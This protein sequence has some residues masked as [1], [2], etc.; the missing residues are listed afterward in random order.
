MRPLVLWLFLDW[1]LSR[2][3]PPFT[4]WPFFLELYI[5]FLP[6]DWRDIRQQQLL[7]LPQWVLYLLSFTSFRNL[8]Y[9]IVQFWTT[10][11]FI[12]SMAAELGLHLCP[13]QSVYNKLGPGTAPQWPVPNSTP[14]TFPTACYVSYFLIA[15]VVWIFQVRGFFV[16]F[17]V[18][19]SV[20][21]E[22]GLTVFNWRYYQS[23]IALYF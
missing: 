20:R 4:A 7:W 12:N 3:F 15:C 16:N 10:F 22:F 23:V 17:G 9:M 2:W 18:Y 5:L 8:Y 14:F 19:H 1:N 13:S 21:S 6:L 11:F